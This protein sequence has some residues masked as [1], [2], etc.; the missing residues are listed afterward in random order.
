M[1]FVQ[2]DT[3]TLLLCEFFLFVAIFTI[4]HS[5]WSGARCHRAGLILSQVG[6]CRT[7]SRIQVP[8]LTEH[9]LSRT[10]E[11]A[12]AEAAERLVDQQLG[13]SP[14]SVSTNNDL[15]ESS[16]PVTVT[17]N[18][19]SVDEPVESANGVAAAAAD[20][21]SCAEAAEAAL[22]LNPFDAGADVFGGSLLE[23][24]TAESTGGGVENFFAE[25]EDD[26]ADV[27]ELPAITA[28]DEAATMV[29]AA[30]RGYRQRAQIQVVASERG[31]EGGEVAAPGNVSQFYAA[32]TKVE[33]RFGGLEE[34][35]TGIVE[36]FDEKS[37]LYDIVYDD[38]DRERGWFVCA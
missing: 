36:K 19:K 3:H 18:K 5:L 7:P 6:E 22:S 2:E 20:S 24:A 11:E 30:Y 21:A 4:R 34:Y 12:M 10:L 9:K 23:L 14:T 38:G 15:L 29:A 16:P 31:R 26:G 8:W 1:R 35:Y 25:E 28:E 27:F 32:G 13:E 37:K 17:V 33:C